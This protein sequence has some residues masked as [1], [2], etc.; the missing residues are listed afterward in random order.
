MSRAARPLVL[1]MLVAAPLGANPA[2]TE[3]G[4]QMYG[5]KCLACHGIDGAGD[6]PLGK[7]MGVPDLRKSALSQAEIEKVIA[8]GKGKMLP[9][10]DRL[11]PEQI[12]AIA[13][14]VRT[15]ITRPT[16]GAPTRAGDGAAPAPTR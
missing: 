13:A 6:K 16:P 9:S 14:H 1:A 8:V 11:T 2:G 15:V 7:K 4:Q 12:S 10:G 3:D 5:K